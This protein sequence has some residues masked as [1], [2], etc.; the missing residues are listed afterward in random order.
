M[1][2][3]KR[4]DLKVVL[5]GLNAADKDIVYIHRQYCLC[6][7]SAGCNCDPVKMTGKEVREFYT[8]EIQ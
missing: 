8:S 4:D 2:N 6:G 7:G 5:K 1:Q 3:V